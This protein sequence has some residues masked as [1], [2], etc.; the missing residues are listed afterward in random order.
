MTIPREYEEAMLAYL[1]QLQGKAPLK[2]PSSPSRPQTKPLEKSEKNTESFD[3]FSFAFKHEE[4]KPFPEEEKVYQHED[5][6]HLLTVYR[7]QTG[8]EK[9]N[10]TAKR[11][12]GKGFNKID[13]PILTP[14][15]EFY[16]RNKFLYRSDLQTVSRL[17]RKYHAQWGE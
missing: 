17:I 9:E 6:D 15:A 2:Q 13:A 5:I 12:N 16:L 7:N 8:D 11:V 10:A 4:P 1:A 14:L 3:L